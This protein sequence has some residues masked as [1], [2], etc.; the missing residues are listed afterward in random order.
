MSEY[1]CISK[2]QYCI[3]LSFALMLIFTTASLQSFASASVQILLFGL[4]NLVVF[5]KIEN[6][7]ICWGIFLVLAA[8]MGEM[9]LLLADFVPFFSENN[10]FLLLPVSTFL[11]L[12]APLFG[13]FDAQHSVEV[14]DCSKGFLYFIVS[15]TIISLVREA[16]GAATIWN[17]KISGL[18]RVKLTCLTHSPSGALLV[19]VSLMILPVMFHRNGGSVHRL[20]TEEGRTKSYQSIQLQEEKDFVKLCLCMLI[21]NLVFGAI[22]ATMVEFAPANI[23]NTT[24]IVTFAS[25]ISVT[26]FTLIIWLFKQGQTLDRYRYTPFL[27]IITTT[28]PM[29]LYVNYYRAEGGAVSSTRLIWWIAF[30]I[31]VWLTAVVTISYTRVVKERLLFGKQPRMLEGMPFVVLQIFLAMLVLMPWSSVLPVL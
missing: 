11:F 1:T 15:G 2:K 14:A 8:L 27:S 23:Q 22:G 6:K 29:M 9:V 10:G 12:S 21:Y 31:G 4:V 18:E 7:R 25:L 30:M 20:Q 28:L 3:L 5:H 26:L 17:H 24:H 16:L 19:L 13:Y